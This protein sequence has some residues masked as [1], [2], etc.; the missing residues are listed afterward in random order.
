MT[1]AKQVLTDITEERIRQSEEWG[2]AAHDDSHGPHD[3]VG[4]I[5]KQNQVAF[6]AFV[7]KNNDAKEWRSRMV[8]V[9]ALAIAAIESYDRLMAEDEAVGAG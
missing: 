5:G 3:W 2:G 9:A 8:K 4:Y 6:A 1:I 7:G